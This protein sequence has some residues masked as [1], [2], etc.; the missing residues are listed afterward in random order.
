MLMAFI[1]EFFRFIFEKKRNF[2]S[3]GWD[4]THPPFIAIGWK[5]FLSALFS[6]GN[7]YTVSMVNRVGE[8]TEI[9]GPSSSP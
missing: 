8:C 4:Q 5:L 6:S 3:P 2:Q 7:A 1:R 9:N